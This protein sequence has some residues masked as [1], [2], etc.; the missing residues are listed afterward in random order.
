M[1]SARNEWV[2]LIDAGCS[3]EPSWLE[4]L[5]AG[6]DRLNGEAGVVLGDHRPNLCD[7]W[8]VAQALAF[9]APPDPTLGLRPPF[10]A[11]SL[12][13][14]RAWE[15]V[16]GF[17]EDLRAA[18]DLL[19]FRALESARIPMVRCPGA[20]VLWRLPTGPIGVFRRFW[21]YSSHHLRA[22]M[23]RTWHLRVMTMD[24]AAAGLIVAGIYKPLLLGLLLLGALARLLRTV[25]RRRKNIQRAAFRPDRLIRVGYLL[26]VADVALWAGA[27]DYWRAR[28]L[29]R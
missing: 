19:F 24:C 18:E 25:G 26:L 20:V 6:R 13:H 16:G 17:P 27:F 14:K 23:F 3:A 29:S 12:L 8:D 2:A 21:L 28:G 9:V 10:I 4:K 11:S 7:E 22:G 5:L 1:R 15:S